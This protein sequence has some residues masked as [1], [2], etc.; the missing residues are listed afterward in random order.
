MNIFS[1]FNEF[2][3]MGL[4]LFLLLITGFVISKK[5]RKRNALRSKMATGIIL[6]VEKLALAKEH[7]VEVKLLVMVMPEKSRNFVGELTETVLL[8]D[9]LCMKIGDK[10][11]VEY[12]AKYKLSL[13]RQV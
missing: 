9:L 8:T 12:A 7:Q 2:V 6:S 11:R 1:V 5:L 10:I 4:V 3:V 13:A